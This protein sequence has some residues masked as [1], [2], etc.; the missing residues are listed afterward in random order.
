[1][2][3]SIGVVVP[4]YDRPVQTVE[5]VESA[6][7]Q[8]RPPDQIVVVDDGSSPDTLEILIARLQSSRVEV[9]VGSHCGHPGRVRNLGLN[10]LDT[11]HVAFLDSDDLWMENKLEIQ[12][13]LALRGA[14]AQG[15][16]FVVRDTTVINHEVENYSPRKISLRNLLASNVICNSSVLLEVQLLSEIG[17]LPISYGVRGIEDYAAWLRIATLTDWT[18]VTEPLVIYSDDPVN[19]MRGTNHFSIPEN[20]LALWDLM[21]WLQQ[22][23]HQVPAAV[24]LALRLSNRMLAGWAARQ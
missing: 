24:R 8:S 17:G 12:E 6:L 4:T 19:S 9:I 14:R 11:S 16:G 2:T 10:H 21:D 23:G 22:R 7:R 3:I 13:E 1:M 18:F 20:V 15:S 5:A